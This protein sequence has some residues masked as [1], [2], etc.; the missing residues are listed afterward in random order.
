ML[1][2]R[3]SPTIIAFG[4]LMPAMRDLLVCSMQYIY[5][6][7]AMVIYLAQVVVFDALGKGVLESSFGG[8]NA[9]IFAYGQTGMRFSV[10]MIK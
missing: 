4:P 10:M 2:F 7:V 1:C 5:V 6:I 9:C 3:N 8:Y